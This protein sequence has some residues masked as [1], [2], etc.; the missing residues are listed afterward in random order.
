[1]ISARTDAP[2][3]I[4]VA[5]TLALLVL[6]ASVAGAQ[7]NSAPG[8]VNLRA[9]QAATP[10]L[11]D[12][13]FNP[14]CTPVPCEECLY[15][16]TYSP[17]HS[18]GAP[19]GSFWVPNT[20]HTNYILASGTLYLVTV[21]GAISLWFP[22][23]WTDASLY[24]FG[25]PGSSPEYP[26]AGVTNGKTGWDFEFLFAYMWGDDQGAGLALPYNYAKQNMSIDGGITWHDFTPIGGEVYSPS[27][28]YRYAVE[29][30]GKQAYFRFTDTG[31]TVDNY[32]RFY[33]CIQ[34]LVPCVATQTEAVTT[35]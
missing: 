12:G 7:T 8:A 15:V 13:G 22:E 10:E 1:M 11:S 3:R 16:D 30:Q 2:M 21:R 28:V 14:A 6:V 19:A 25:T 27:H 4:R 9:L 33:I 31:P 17:A 5:V 32:G 24:F 29:G 35:N 20:N 18:V 34:K 23:L 26:T